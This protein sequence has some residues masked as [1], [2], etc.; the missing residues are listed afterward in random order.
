[1]REHDSIGRGRTDSTSVMRWTLP[2]DGIAIR[3]IAV[4]VM[5]PRAP[6]RNVI[7]P[8]GREEDLSALG[9]VVHYTPE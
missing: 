2:S 5:E 6:D 8:R 7:E 9:G 1:M 3:Q 4:V